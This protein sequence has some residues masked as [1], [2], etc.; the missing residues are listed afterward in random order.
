MSEEIL[1]EIVSERTETNKV[2]NLGNNKRRLICYASPIHYKNK[3]GK[4]DDIELKLEDDGE[5]FRCDK[6]KVKFEIKK[7]KKIAKHIR[8]KYDNARQFESTFLK[9]KIDGIE[10]I[11]GEE[12]ESTSKE[13][14]KKIVNSLPSGI[15]VIDSLDAV[16]YR[17]YIEIDEPIENFRIVE[18]LNF[19]GMR[20][21]NKKEDNRYI[22]D[23]YER[24][25]FVDKNKNLL[26]SIDRPFFI[27]NSG[28]KNID[29]IH[30]LEEINGRLIY[31]KYPTRKGQDDLVL[32]SYPILIDT[33]TFYSK[34]ADGYV[35]QTRVIGWDGCH[36]AADGSFSDN[37]S[38]YNI[39]AMYASHESNK[40]ESTAI[41]RSFFYFDTSTL[42]AGAT[43]SQAI[44]K[45]YGY[46]DANSKVSAQKGTQATP[47]TYIDYDACD[48]DHV[49]EHK[50]GVFEE[51][52]GD[53]D[54]NWNTG[55]YNILNIDG[56]TD[57]PGGGT[58][59]DGRNDIDVTGTTKICCREYTYD[60]LDV[61]PAGSFKNGCYY[62]NES[63]INKRPKLEIDYVKGTTVHIK[64]ETH[65]KG[66]VIY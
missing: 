62:A 22:P 57:C 56:S 65:V 33:T 4:W 21:R 10:N 24:F 47:L 30:T 52:S 7:N 9:I 20:C 23:K 17:N 15:R 45:I 39:S 25:N 14:D 48:V 12:Y 64:G 8:L 46:A 18:E 51:N 6:N 60:Y 35:S 29:V 61:Q 59:D 13:T 11:T 40:L 58:C 42:G 38:D 54:G 32:A 49:T 1:G 28:I 5:K 3:K 41:T 50:Y 26:F 31:T 19:K 36:D 63:D 43:I 44:L 27:D 55:K 66:G 16:S 34:T 2:F 37:A 53:G